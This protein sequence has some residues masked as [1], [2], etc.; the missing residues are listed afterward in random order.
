MHSLIQY[1]NVP[2]EVAGV[3]LSLHRRWS[4][5]NSRTNSDPTRSITLIQELGNSFFPWGVAVQKAHVQNAQK[6]PLGHISGEDFIQIE[7]GTCT[8]MYIAA[9]FTI[10][11]TWKQPIC[12][13]RDEGR[14]KMWYIHTME[15][16]CCCCWVTSDSSVT[17]SSV[18]HQT[19]VHG[20]FPGKNTWVGCQF[21]LQEIFP[22]QGLNLCLLHGQADSSH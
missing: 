1:S 2:L 16:G 20:I 22:T 18:A 13:S 6:E 14:K 21:V 7:K 15:Y 9:L 4:L 5:G 12:P 11:K 10:A 19:P 3:I 8:P 17:L